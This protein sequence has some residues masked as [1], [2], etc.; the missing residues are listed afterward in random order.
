MDK[1][2]R[3]YI[4]IFLWKWMYFIYKYIQY[5]S[6]CP[7]SSD[8]F[9]IVCYYIKWVT[10][11]WTYS[12]NSKSVSYLRVLY[13][14]LRS[15]YGSLTLYSVLRRMED[16]LESRSR[17]SKLLLYYPY[18]L[19]ITLKEKIL[20]LHI[21]SFSSIFPGINGRVCW[22]SRWW[23]NTK[24]SGITFFPLRKW[25]MIRWNFKKTWVSRLKM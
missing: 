1:I 2:S 6:V 10:T 4:Q 23:R 13:V 16:M 19:I 7:R 20:F 25:I 18:C 22:W 15:V 12:I 5:I 17:V 24:I 3:T 8:P 11:S 14:I 21:F 9:D